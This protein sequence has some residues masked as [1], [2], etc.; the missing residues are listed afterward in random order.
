VATANTG[1]NWTKTYIY[2]PYGVPTAWGTI[3]T[4]PRFRYTGQAAFPSANLYYYKAREY[5]PGSG[6]FLQTDPVGYK[7]DVN[8]YTYVANDPVDGT[9]P[10]GDCLNCATALIGAVIGAAGGAGVEVITQVATTGKVSDWGGVGTAALGGGVAGAVTG[11]TLSPTAGAAAGGFVQS[12]A[13]SLR[14]NPHDISGAVGEGL[15]GAA[16]GA[17]LGK[18]GKFLSARGANAVARNERMAT[19]MAGRI[20]KGQVK[21]LSPKTAIKMG[22]AAVTKSL[23]P[24]TLASGLSKLASPSPEKSDKP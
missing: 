11:F 9:D 5:D 12:T 22:A 18:G 13:D 6:K 24:A 14:S 23:V 7:D 10:N 3:G 17:V 20:A 8:L 15:K 21:S 2:D 4:D 19:M 1:G 16:I